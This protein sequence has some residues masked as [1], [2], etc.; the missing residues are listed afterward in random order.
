MKIGWELQSRC[1]ELSQYSVQGRAR[2]R[3]KPVVLVV[4]IQESKAKE[5]KR[6]VVGELPYKQLANHVYR[7]IVFPGP[8]VYSNPY[9]NPP[10]GL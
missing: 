2:S 7:L 5:R 8:A 1:D 9:S 6:D 4:L 3:A 10:N